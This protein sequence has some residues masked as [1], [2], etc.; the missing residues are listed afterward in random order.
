MQKKKTSLRLRERER[1][2]EDHNTTR[3]INKFVKCSFVMVDAARGEGWGEVEEAGEVGVT[4]C[5]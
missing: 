2:L 1:A 5:Q 4:M 3:P